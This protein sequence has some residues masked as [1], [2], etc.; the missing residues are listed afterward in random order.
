MGK[1]RKV[2]PRGF[3]PPTNGLGNRC[4]I[5][6]ELRGHT[7]PAGNPL[8]SASAKTFLTKAEQTRA[9]ENDPH[10][11]PGNLNPL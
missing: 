9:T 3:E 2:A 8:T 7:A 5:R 10:V 11:L 1:A 6:A 4:S